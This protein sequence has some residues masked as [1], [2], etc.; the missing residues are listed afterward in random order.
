MMTAQ[1]SGGSTCFGITLDDDCRNPA[2]RY[3]KWCIACNEHV[4][5]HTSAAEIGYAEGHDISAYR[6]STSVQI[7][8]LVAISAATPMGIVEELLADEYY[9]VQDAVAM[10]DDLTEPL[11]HRICSLRDM[12]PAKT[13]LDCRA[14]LPESVLRI[15][16]AKEN[17][18]IQGR[19]AGRI[20]T[21]PDILCDIAENHTPNG[22]K[23]L[24][25]PRLPQNVIIDNIAKRSRGRH[26]VAVANPAA[27]PE[28][29]AKAAE[30]LRKA[31]PSPTNFRGLRRIAANPNTPLPLVRELLEAYGTELMTAVFGNPSATKTLLQFAFDQSDLSAC[32]VREGETFLC[33]NDLDDDLLARLWPLA[34]TS[35]RVAIAQHEHCGPKTRALIWS[36]RAPQA[37]SALV[38]RSPEMPSDELARLPRGN[39][40]I[41]Y[42]LA[43]H[44]NVST[45]LLRELSSAACDLTRTAVTEHPNVEPSVLIMLALD[46]DET[47][48]DAATRRLAS[49]R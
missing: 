27:P 43:Q 14:K 1:S 35:T 10:R 39:K 40:H 2:E 6:K 21:P 48:A 31:R 29:L 15:L 13:M 3:G 41:Q 4:G 9:Q 25:N 26:I 47:V 30:H 5:E 19:L 34:T 42:A 23:A 17:G 24:T 32:T 28:V 49:Q 37:K 16:A 45:D 20:D 38:N 11:M 22:C 36:S 46:S 33:R 18:G 44:P 7:R 8:N 12:R